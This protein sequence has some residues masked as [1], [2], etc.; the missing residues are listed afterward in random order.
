MEPT[1]EAFKSFEYPETKQLL[2]TF[3]TLVT[4]VFTVS[5]VFAEKFLDSQTRRDGTVLYVSWGL[6]FLSLVLGGVSL[7]QLHIAG[8]LAYRTGEL[9]SWV[10]ALRNAYLWGEVAGVVFAGG[11]VTLSWTAFRRRVVGERSE[12]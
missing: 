11:L 5:L 3:L 6:L 10:A 1:L 2:V 7:H 4:T 9:S 12:S 8:I